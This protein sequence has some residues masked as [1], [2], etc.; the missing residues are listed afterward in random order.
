M[1]M[2]CSRLDT[3]GLFAEG[4]ST[5]R[6]NLSNHYYTSVSTFSSEFSALVSSVLDAPLPSQKADADNATEDSAMTTKAAIS[7]W[8]D[9]RKLAKRVVKAVQEILENAMRK[10]SQLCRR[11]FEKELRD[12]DM[13]LE[14]S[15]ASRRDSIVGSL[16]GIADESD[17]LNE[18]LQ[19]TSEDL[20]NFNGGNNAFNITVEDT[21]NYHQNIA[22]TPRHDNDAEKAQSPDPLPHQPTPEDS[23][24]SPDTN[25][26]PHAITTTAINNDSST[27]NTTTNPH[28]DAH[29]HP[30]H[31]NHPTA[32]PTPPLSSSSSSQNPH[33]RPLF[34]TGGPIPWYMQTFDPHGT[35]IHEERWTG[36]DLAREMSEELSDMDEEELSG[37]VDMNNEGDVAGGVVEEE[38]SAADSLSLLLHP[39]AADREARRKRKAVVDARRRRRRRNWF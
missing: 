25:G 26:D 28:P 30:A 4:L 8:K 37:L 7:E 14:A 29:P 32:P 11:P 13:M 15:L 36:R 27:N 23:N 1:L 21:S 38:G 3:K 35:T 34:P 24:A 22:A 2:W 18:Q 39:E 17:R 9:K 16:A 12:L 19:V 33:S 5:M 10:E 20:K 31:P 6:D